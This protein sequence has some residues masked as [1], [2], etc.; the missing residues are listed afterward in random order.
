MILVKNE[1][2]NLIKNR[3]NN[4]DAS[5]QIFSNVESDTLSRLSKSIAEFINE[6]GA[7]RPTE[8]KLWEA[9]LVTVKADLDRLNS[10][11]AERIKIL[12]MSQQESATELFNLTSPD[13]QKTYSN[14]INS[15]NNLM[16]Y[17]KVK[18]FENL[19]S[20]YFRD[21]ITCIQRKFPQLSLSRCYKLYKESILFY[22]RKILL[23]YLLM[24][25][26]SLESFLKLTNTNDK[27]AVAVD[28]LK[29]FCDE[30]NKIVDFNQRIKSQVIMN[31]EFR[32]GKY[33]LRSEQV[34]DIDLLTSLDQS[35][36]FFKSV[37]IQRMMAAGK[38][39]V[40]GTI[41]VVTKALDNT[42]LSILAPPSSLY[43]SNTTAMQ[44]RTYLYFKKKGKNFS[45]PRFSIGKDNATLSL[46]LKTVLNI[47]DETMQ[48]RNYLI[49]NPD[50]LHS[51]LNSYIEVL[52]NVKD[53]GSQDFFDILVGFGKI[54]RIFR[55]QSSIIL[56]EIDMT[57]DPR[58]ELNYP[59]QDNE[60]YNMTA[61]ALIAD[62]VEF[63]LFDQEIIET[64]L[65]IYSNNQASLTTENY[66]KCRGLILNYIDTQL[67]EPSS[68]W[69]KL[70]FAKLNQN[71]TNL[72]SKNIMNFLRNSSGKFNVVVSISS[73]IC[74]S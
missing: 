41:S 50:A 49:M 2:L 20:C 11:F 25:Q 42:K 52:L 38:T 3:S 43:Q 34:K 74:C 7:N 51:F 56:D 53:D 27:K 5:K 4:N 59:T 58:K 15:L 37:V 30:L 60:P 61:V 23:D 39:L 12:A 9:S 32:S 44:N 64:G 28:D 63:A 16:H 18:N 36:Q 71:N 24:L 67:S 62:I 22:S 66:E 10:F 45:F 29:L 48:S 47:I 40:L 33:R 69:Y 21:S 46:Y 68:L 70:I 54:Y 1:L 19:Y 35:K 26:N 31:F 17:R 72:T 73:P 14:V 6:N 55:R 65:G 57:M 13:I 8:I